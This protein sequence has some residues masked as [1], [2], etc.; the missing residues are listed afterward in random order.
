[1]DES[2]FASNPVNFFWS[3][4]T[5]WQ[6]S[7]AAAWRNS[8]TFF[9]FDFTFARIGTELAMTEGSDV[10]MSGMR[11]V[12]MQR[13]T[14][15]RERAAVRIFVLL[16]SLAAFALA[17]AQS[18]PN[19]PVRMVIAAA[20]GGSTDVLGRVL[21]QRLSERLGQP[22]VPENRGGAGGAVAAEAVAKAAPDGY[23][24]LM[25]NDQ[26]VISA[27][28]GAKLP[29]DPFRDFAPIGVVARGPVVL[30]VHPAF[31]ARTIAELVALAKANPGKYAFSSC[32][33][34]TVLHLA[35]ELLNLQAGIDLAHV[36]YRGCAPAMAD[37]VS[38][39]VPIFFTVLGNAAPFERNGKVRLLGVATAQRI[40]SHPELPTIAESGFPGY[41]AY[42]WFGMLAPAGTPPDI[43]QRLAAE[44]TSAVP[45]PQVSARIRGFSLE[46]TP[47]GPEALGGL[48]RS[49]FDKWQRVVRE[50]HI[51][52]E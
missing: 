28:A 12:V 42:P 47:L 15:Q 40:A 37:A 1:M 23:T 44:I 31:P 13:Q 4:A 39:Q 7:V 22:F 20:P 38:G 19:R 32:G 10:R 49:D 16:A 46:P 14:Q 51:T 43:V 30:G 29:Y 26:L 50:A 5:L 17:Q 36:P 11:G 8:T 41:D 48:M 27:A 35:G 33:N 2:P 34:G 25:T 3:R 52:V 45:I 6:R 24:I 9:D 18:Y 21:A